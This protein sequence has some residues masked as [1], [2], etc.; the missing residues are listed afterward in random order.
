M[1]SRYVFLSL[2]KG[3]HFQKLL[4]ILIMMTCFSCVLWQARTCFF[5]YNQQP[6]GSVLRL[7]TTEHVQLSF[8]FCR[9]EYA[10]TRNVDGKF[11]NEKLELLKSMMVVTNNGSIDLLKGVSLTYEF[12]IASDP[13]Y[14]CREITLPKVVIHSIVIEHESY[15]KSKNFH[16]FIHPSGMFIFPEFV[17]K[18]SSRYFRGMFD[19]NEKLS[20]ESYDMSGNPRAKCTTFNPHSCKNRKIIEEYNRTL[21]CSYP[22]QRLFCNRFFRM[23]RNT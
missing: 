8:T 12:V 14:L 16:L 13:R 9:V 4:N 2:I 19:A 1:D 21:G 20:L 5:R 7:V 3:K 18:Y 23:K 15:L 17:L 6:T 10:L 22:I 11:F